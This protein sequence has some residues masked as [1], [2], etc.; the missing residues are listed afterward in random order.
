LPFVTWKVKTQNRVGRFA[1]IP[2][3]TSPGVMA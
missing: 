2:P 1:L 3:E